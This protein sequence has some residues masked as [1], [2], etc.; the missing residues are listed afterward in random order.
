VNVPWAYAIVRLPA[1]GRGAYSSYA[2]A[3]SSDALRVR[4]RAATI[5]V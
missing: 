5:D 3:Y 4:P 1:L 2:P